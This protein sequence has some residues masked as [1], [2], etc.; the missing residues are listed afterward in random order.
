MADEPSFQEPEFQEPEF[1]GPSDQALDFQEPEIQEPDEY[2]RLEY[3]ILGDLDVLYVAWF[4]L[5]DQD[6]WHFLGFNYA[7]AQEAI[8]SANGNRV[9]AK[10][11]SQ[12][13]FGAVHSA[14]ITIGLDEAENI[15]ILTFSQWR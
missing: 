14:S 8:E 15:Q 6:N 12:N 4:S 5:D 11:V 3:E 9:V 1:P 10:A 13:L 2:S 7:D